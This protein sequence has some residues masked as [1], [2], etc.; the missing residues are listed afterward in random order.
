VVGNHDH[1]LSAFIE[2]T[3]GE[4]VYPGGRPGTL[5]EKEEMT[6]ARKFVKMLNAMGD[7]DS[8]I[9]WNEF[10][11]FA[12]I[13]DKQWII[14]QGEYVELVTAVGGDPVI[15]LTATMLTELYRHPRVKQLARDQ[16][17]AHLSKM[18]MFF[19]AYEYGMVDK[20]TWDAKTTVTSYGTEPWWGKPPKEAAAL[21]A[22]FCAAI[23]A[24]HKEFLKSLEWVVDIPVSFGPGRLV[25]LHAGLHLDW[26]AEEQIA[27]L[28]GERD[29]DPKLM[30]KKPVKIDQLRGKART[31]PE[32]KY[33]LLSAKKI[34]MYEKYCD[35]VLCSGVEPHPD[36]VGKALVAVGHHGYRDIGEDNLILDLSGGRDD[37]ALEA[38]VFPQRELVGS[39][40]LI[41]EKSMNNF[42][43]LRSIKMFGGC[44]GFKPTFDTP[45]AKTGDEEKSQPASEG[46][47]P[48]ED[49][50][51][52]ECRKFAS[53]IAAHHQKIH[54]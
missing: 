49:L 32:F 48:V 36:L 11:V 2:V 28:K 12:S 30:T 25:C 21:R 54:Q 1:A 16:M 53:A 5:T 51:E 37:L 27:C 20:D 10:E 41:H 31:F 44:A 22:A 17:P 24:S 13:V 39:D 40:S 35:G 4:S 9:E 8:Y 26:S 14:T 42:A 38:F 33:T 46:H 43:K 7:E 23:P 15:G 19:A 18:V 3:T 6:V 47:D 50:D 52:E 29:C 34:Q 45:V